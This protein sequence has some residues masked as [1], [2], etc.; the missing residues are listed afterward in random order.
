MGFVGEV[1]EVGGELVR[2][3]DIELLD[4]PESDAVA[5][6]VLRVVHL[7]FE[8]RVEV[9]L[10]DGRIVAVQQARTNGDVPD[11]HVGQPVWVRPSRSLRP[12]A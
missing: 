11:R 1:S 10:E 4:A 7:G 3:H 12:V 6:K 2:P 8:V 5:G 9:A